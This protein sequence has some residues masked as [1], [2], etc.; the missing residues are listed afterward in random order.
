MQVTDITP[1]KASDTFT[2]FV[3]ITSKQLLVRYLDFRVKNG[4]IELR[5]RNFDNMSVCMYIKDF[6]NIWKKVIN[7]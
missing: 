1:N 7:I 3:P 6:V 5:F 4:F 2:F